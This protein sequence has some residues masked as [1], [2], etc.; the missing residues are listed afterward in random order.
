MVDTPASFRE[1]NATMLK[2]TPVERL[3]ELD[4]GLTHKGPEHTGGE[5]P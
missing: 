3:H 1:G 4:L 2:R 5:V